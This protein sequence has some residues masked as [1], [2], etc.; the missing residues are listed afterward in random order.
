MSLFLLALDGQRYHHFERLLAS[1]WRQRS[2]EGMREC[3]RDLLPDLAA[4]QDRYR[5]ADEASFV[6]RIATTNV[7]FDRA[8]WRALV[9]EILLYTAVE[10]PEF[11]TAPDTL[12]RIVAPEWSGDEAASRERFVPIQ[13]VHFGT[14]DIAFGSGFYRPD[15]AGINHRADIVRL[16]TYLRSVDPSTWTVDHLA[17]LPDLVD[18]DREDELAFARQCWQAL[19]ELYERAERDNWVI[20]GEVV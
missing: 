20:V 19:R 8:T 13:Q 10:V 5:I 17:A 14:H 6:S 18:E 4:F 11:Q 15:A 12:L 3:C 2:L 7:P 9:G 16:T 1:S